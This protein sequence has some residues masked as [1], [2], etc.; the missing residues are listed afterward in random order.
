[1]KDISKKMHIGIE[2][3]IWAE[4][5]WDETDTNSDVIV[6]FPNRS[7]WIATFF[8][9]NNIQTLR[10]KNNQTGECMN[11]AYFWSSDM[12]LIDM[13]TRE[14]IEQVIHDLI[15]DGSLNPYLHVILMLRLKRMNIIPPAFSQQLVEYHSFRNFIASDPHKK[16]LF[17]ICISHG[18]SPLILNIQRLINLSNPG[19]K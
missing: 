8:T 1:M 4:G 9:Y 17:P 19:A 14:R 15:E 13:V 2:A 6:V 18:D 10:E 3:E 16:E 5:T 7:K 11:S 12:V